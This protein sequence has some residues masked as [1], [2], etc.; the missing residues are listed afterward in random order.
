MFYNYNV[1]NKIYIEL[2]VLQVFPETP[3]TRCYKLPNA[4]TGFTI[5]LGKE[6]I[7][8]RDKS[9][10]EVRRKQINKKLQ[11]LSLQSDKLKKQLENLE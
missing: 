10:A 3:K 6:E 8:S 11:E 1:S 9:P 5:W 7:L 4:A 2:E